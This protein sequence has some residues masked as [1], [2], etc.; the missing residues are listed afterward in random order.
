M[1]FYSQ[2][3]FKGANIPDDYIQYAIAST[4]IVNVLTTLICVKLIDRLGRKP[5]LVF[6][7]IIMILD[8]IALTVFLAMKDQVPIFSYLSI[9]CFV[10]FVICFAVG[11][12]KI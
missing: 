10:I 1:F 6:P 9:A 5:L 7:M 2:S 12:G 8:F 11:L 4:G 3:I